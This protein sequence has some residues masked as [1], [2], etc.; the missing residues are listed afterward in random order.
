MM[1]VLESLIRDHQGEPIREVLTLTNSGW[2]EIDVS[3]LHPRHQC[4]P[5]TY[6]SELGGLLLYGG[7]L[8]HGRPQL[9]EMLILLPSS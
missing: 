2:K 5:L 8:G 7:E 3:P 4:S 9:Q 6:D 1:V